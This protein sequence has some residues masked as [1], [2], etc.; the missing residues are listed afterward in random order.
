MPAVPAVSAVTVTAPPVALAETFALITVRDPYPTPL[1]APPMI[2][3]A[4]FVAAVLPDA[5]MR[6]WPAVVDAVRV[7]LKVYAV[8]AI[9]TISPSDG[10]PVMFTVSEA[11]VAA[12]VFVTAPATKP[13]V[14]ADN[15]PVV[16]PMVVGLTPSLRKVF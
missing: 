16:I 4:K 8:P 15:T 12:T 6:T 3:A 7:V 9:V 13:K 2:A 14:E 1:P 11:K 5:P 10:R